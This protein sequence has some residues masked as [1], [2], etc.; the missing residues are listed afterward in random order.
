MTN[1]V[2]RTSLPHHHDISHSLGMFLERCYKTEDDFIAYT[3]SMSETQSRHNMKRT[4]YLLPPRQRTIARFIN[5]S[6][7]VDWS[8]KMLEAYH[9]LNQEERALYA[10]VP[11][12]ASLIDE[13][14][15]TMKCINYI[16]K[17]CKQKEFS[18]CTIKNSSFAS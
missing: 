7:W 1:G 9:K 5:L 17:E 13:L 10:F 11:A 8:Q 4:A 12:N 15:E 16:E 14:S 18:H 2:T 6:N 3:K